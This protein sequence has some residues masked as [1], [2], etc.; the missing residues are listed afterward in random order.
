MRTPFVFVF[1][2]VFHSHTYGQDPSYR[3][4]W[5]LE[6]KVSKRLNLD[7]VVGYDE[8]GY[9]ALKI[10]HKVNFGIGP[11]A[12]NRTG[13]PILQHYDH[14]LKMDR[15]SKI[16]LNYRQGERELEG[17][18]QVKGNLYLFTSFADNGDKN[19]K[20]FVQSVNKQNLMTSRD[21]ME[22]ANIDYKGKRKKNSGAY[23]FRVSRDST[24][25]FV[26]C[27]LPFE[28]NESERFALKVFDQTMKLLW[29]KDVDLPYTDEL[30]SLEDLSVDDAGNVY[31]LGKVFYDKVKTRVNGSPNYHYTILS[32]KKNGEA[33]REYKVSLDDKFL[34]EMQISPDDDGDIVCAG[35]YSVEGNRASGEHIT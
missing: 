19:H 22:I 3:I 34:E 10:L 16:N 33:F 1:L 9:Y 18:L 15:M 7:V 27:T 28:K 29:Q 25:I 21:D 23:M 35:F 6:E 24:R 14:D 32:Y 11:L 17:M 5:G 26:F 30:F 4:K 12:T 2:F 13:T 8:T 31:L 20:L